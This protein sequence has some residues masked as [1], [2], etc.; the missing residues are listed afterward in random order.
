MSAS[1][2][3]RD[4]AANLLHVGDVAGAV[5][6]AR[7]AVE[8]DPRD[9]ESQH[10][11]G[12]ALAMSGDL[13]GAEKAF[14][15][16][17]QANPKLYKPQSSLAS[18]LAQ[19]GRWEEAAK[20]L[21]KATVLEPQ[22]ARLWV[23]LG[24]AYDKV[25]RIPDAIRALERALELE[26]LV[27]HRRLLAEA[28]LRGGMPARALQLLTPR[29]VQLGD[30]GEAWAVLARAAHAARDP[31][32]REALEGASATQLKESIATDLA[33]LA[34]DAGLFDAGVRLANHAR[35]AAP[36][37]WNDDSL[38]LEARALEAAGRGDDAVMLLERAVNERPT[39]KKALHLAA[40]HS[41]RGAPERALPILRGARTSFPSSTDVLVALG[42]VAR[43][44][45]ELDTAFSAFEAA[46]Q[47]DANHPGACFGL[48]SLRAAIGASTEAM[49]LLERAVRFDPTNPAPFA[50]LL[51]ADLSASR[52]TPPQRCALRRRFGA[53][54]AMVPALAR[55]TPTPPLGARR[56]RVG[57]LGGA[58]NDAPTA[59]L[60]AGILEQHDRARFEVF[61]YSSVAQSDAVTARL[62]TLDL[63]YRDVLRMP[64]HII[65]QRIA[66]DG[67]DVLVALDVGS[68]SAR[69]RVLCYRPAPVQLVYLGDPT[70]GFD[71]ADFR[72]GDPV[73]DPGGTEELATE[74]T[75]RLAHTSF[76]YGWAARPIPASPRSEPGVVYACFADTSHVSDAM[77]RAITELLSR[78][79]MSRVLLRAPRAGAPR[80][81]QRLLDRLG[82]ALA[83]RV[84]LLPPR[85]GVDAHLADYAFVDVALD[86]FPNSEPVT[87]C[88]ALAMGVPVVTLAPPDALGRSGASILHEVA[89]DDLVAGT[90]ADFVRIA[91]TLAADRA[92]LA[93][94]RAELPELVRRT[95]LG[96]PNRFT[97]SIEALFDAL[98]RRPPTLDLAS[99]PIPA[100]AVQLTSSATLV[101]PDSLDTLSTFSLIEQRHYFED[102]VPFVMSILGPGQVC[103][104]I[105]ASYGAYAIEMARRIGPSGR[106]VA[107]EPTASAVTLLRASAAANGLRNLQIHQVAL[108]D[109]EGTARL[110]QGR[111]PEQNHLDVEGAGDEVAVRSLA[112]FAEDLRGVSFIKLDTSGGEEAIVR[113]GAE[114]FRQSAPLVMFELKHGDKVNS[115]LI[116]AFVRLGFR[117][118]QLCPGLGALVPFDPTNVDSGT[119]NLFAATEGRVAEL[120]ARNVCLPRGTATTARA[121]TDDAV[122]AWLAQRPGLLSL[123]LDKTVG[124]AGLALRYLISSAERGRPLS[125][126]LGSLRAGIEAA[127]REIE[128][129]VSPFTRLTGARLALDLGQKNVCVSLLQPLASSTSADLLNASPNEPFACVFDRYADRPATNLVELIRTQA[130]EATIKLSAD[131]SYFQGQSGMDGLRRFFAAGGQDDEMDRRLGL[132]IASAARRAPAALP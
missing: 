54:F 73:A 16:S 84:E 4:R 7:Q 71:G 75:L 113:G 13:A 15:K 30:D 20:A 122:R 18:L 87:T 102:E 10:I 86:S 100:R 27:L 56:I 31:I 39:P 41:R 49:E 109:R 120:A 2:V 70:T 117:M 28:H 126:R 47:L 74:T 99:L 3:L 60:V 57:Y 23:R 90:P 125:E 81:Q 29:S 76:C 130:L 55:R 127:N 37:A 115:G 50:A 17:A 123:G 38:L 8:A 131:S 26:D 106:V 32:L 33:N 82:A 48:G 104:D 61:V 108:A 42:H 44:S 5:V 51:S 119:P 88:E 105:G 95:P 40:L 85:N 111:T 68:R 114:L 91:S 43:E 11:L 101:V 110:V 19:Q 21:R 94:L 62:R 64:D 96:D 6:A 92:R 14:R 128:S 65:A 121:A 52:Y 46:L 72:L 79:P 80:V 24:Q 53:R 98:A 1:S 124:R 93:A 36:D 78:E 58:F 77:L 107:F 25:D 97:R 103:A 129:A 67:I 9:A 83:M 69:T 63:T 22:A 132:T 116:D 12:N 112:T 45:N 89:L 35:S 59:R 66:D 34:I 118:Y